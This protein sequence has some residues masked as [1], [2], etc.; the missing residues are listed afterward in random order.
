MTEGTYCVI[1]A[2]AAGLATARAFTGR[3]LS[4]EVFEAA[5]DIGGLWDARR[6][7]TR[8]SS[9]T[10]VIASKA[11][12]AFPDFPMPQEYPDYPGHELVMRYLRAFADTYELWPH[13]RLN[14]AVDRVR[15]LPDGPPEAGWEVTLADGVRRTYAG[16]VVATGHDRL[17]RRIDI[18]GTP[19][20][21]VLHSSEYRHPDQVLRKRVLVVGAGQSAADILA[22]SAVNAALTL[23]SSRR[24][25]YCMPKYMFG[26]TTDS[27][28]QGRMWRPLRR[29]SLELFFAYLRRRSATF[30]LPVPA[31]GPEIVIPML[32]DQIHHHYAHGDI[33]AK[34]GVQSI[35]DDRVTFADGT[36]EKVDLVLLATG[37][38]PDYPV[39]DREHLNWPDGTPRPGL[40]LNIFPPHTRNLFVVGMV[41]PIGSHWDVYTRQ[42]DLIA[43][44]LL[45]RGE[46]P[47][48]AARF[49]HALLGAQPNLHAG[50]ELYHAEQYPLVVEKQEYTN[51]LRR[52]A[53]LL[54]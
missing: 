30:G 49:E 50:L 43:D 39:V 12:Q 8:M 13:I 20:V 27:M 29:R 1:G 33:V 7:D 23:H 44:Y 46:N 18:P 40:Y 25:F 16:V 10:H 28:L 31:S 15:P 24:G 53:R 35:D 41:R 38:V 19:S 6:A 48:R 54:K 14:T 11:L 34:P 21:P 9:N 22:D 26:R 51:Q 36:E 52:Q 42:A 45:V 3:G 37:Y 5:G 47:T 17:P 2:G 4:V 32:G